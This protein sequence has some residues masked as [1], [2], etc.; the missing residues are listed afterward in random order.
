MVVGGSR[1]V[2][3]GVALELARSGFDLIVTYH[4]DI[5]GA[6][7]TESMAIALGAK[8]DLHKMDLN[9][10]NIALDGVRGLGL[11]KL[12]FLCAGLADTFVF[13]YVSGRIVFGAS[14]VALFRAK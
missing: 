10:S 1:R 4:T 3:R 13:Q 8:V 7:E 2:G 5:R 11:E 12:E 14:A 6:R 9:H